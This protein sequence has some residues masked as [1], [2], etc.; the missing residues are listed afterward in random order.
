VNGTEGLGRF[1][2]LD[3]LVVTPKEPL[4]AKEACLNKVRGEPE[5]V[6]FK[7]GAEDE[8][9]DG[10]DGERNQVG[11][12]VLEGETPAEPAACRREGM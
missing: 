3:K 7:T 1:N 12:R 8:E 2:E 10:E 9:T 5:A 6:R 4:G 11:E